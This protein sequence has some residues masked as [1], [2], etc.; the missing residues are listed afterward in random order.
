M[1]VNQWIQFAVTTPLQEA[2]AQALDDADQP[3]EGYPK[4]VHCG[5]PPMPASRADA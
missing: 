4:C 5:L 3:Y 2:V 1:L